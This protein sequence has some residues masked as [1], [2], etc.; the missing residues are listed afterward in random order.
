MSTATLIKGMSLHT[1][2]VNYVAGVPTPVT[3]E[4]IKALKDAGWGN[5]F[6]FTSEAPAV[7]A[8]EKAAPVK[9]GGVKVVPKPAVKTVTV[10]SGGE[11]L[12][13]GAAAAAAQVKDGE[14]DKGDG[15]TDEVV[16]V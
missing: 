2:G 5:R 15:D 13:T 12:D 6:V 3:D 8:A 7:P 10:A 14:G 9:K 16:E 11:L 4:K 1:G